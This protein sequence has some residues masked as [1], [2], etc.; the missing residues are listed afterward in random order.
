MP[1]RRD[2]RR[3]A[4]CGRPI[5]GSRCSD[6][7]APT[8]P[9]RSPTS[10]CSRRAAFTASS[11]GA[12]CTCRPARATTSTRSRRASLG[13]RGQPVARDRRQPELS[14]VERERSTTRG[15]G[16]STTGSR[17]SYITGSHNFKVGFNNAYLHHEN[18]T[19]TEPGD[20]VLLQL[21]QRRADRRS[22]TASA[23]NRRGR[24]STTT[25]GS[26]RRTA[27]RWVAGRWRA[28]SASTPSRT[29]SRS[30][31]SAPTFLAPNLNVPFAE[32]RQHAAG[33]T[34]RRRWARPTT[35]SATARRR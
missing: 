35:C 19:Y 7:S 25:W 16:T 3:H 29:A 31:R 21:R 17:R 13:H 27:G 10:C 15:T 24:T 9:H 23:A 18:T 22:S 11:A 34:S 14:C 6:S 5:A 12:T 26:S 8:G 2:R 30:R 33:K 1:V 32:D 20:G 28:A 4:G